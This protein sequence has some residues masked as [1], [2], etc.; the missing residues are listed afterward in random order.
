MR[1]VVGIDAMNVYEG[2]TLRI[3]G[4]LYTLVGEYWPCAAA[5]AAAA[6]T[7]IAAAVPSATSAAGRRGGRSAVVCTL[8]RR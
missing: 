1:Q 4:L 7:T 3:L 8:V 2:N 6:T 5:A